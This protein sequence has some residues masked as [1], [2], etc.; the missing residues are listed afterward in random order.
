MS[1]L[2]AL[3]KLEFLDLGYNRIFS[4]IPFVSIHNCKM[5]RDIIL[6]NNPI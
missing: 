3:E 2:F 1:E 4:G 6:W 5:L